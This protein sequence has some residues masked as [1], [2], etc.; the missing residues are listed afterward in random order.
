MSKAEQPWVKWY[1]S[2]WRSD[3]GLRM[4]GL[5]A[6]GMWAELLAIMQEA[7]PYG[8]L[9]VNGVPPTAKQLAVMTGATAGQVETLLEEL[10]AAGVPGVSDDGVVFSRRMVRD[11]EK[12]LRDK[13]NGKGGGNPRL[14]GGVNPP[15]N[16]VDKAHMPEARSQKPE[17]ENHS[18]A[19]PAP[20][21]AEGKDI[22]WEGRVIRLSRRDYDRWRLAYPNADIDAE[23]QAADDYYAT[24]RPKDGNWFFAVSSWLKRANGAPRLSVVNGGDKPDPRG[25]YG[26]DWF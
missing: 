14:K 11:R 18:N 23:L 25:E 7:S 24:N 15:D 1:W 17:E 19:P 9:L 6:R 10:K 26:R 22:A 20:T 21:A 5:A 3:P 13:A 16:G 12:Q 2:D 4:C 8:Y